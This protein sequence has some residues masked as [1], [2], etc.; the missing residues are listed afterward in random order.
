MLTASCFCNRGHQSLSLIANDSPGSIE[1]HPQDGGMRSCMQHRSNHQIRYL[2]RYTLWNSSMRIDIY[3]RK[4]K[5]RHRATTD[6]SRMLISL[7][8]YLTRELGKLQTC[9]W[10][11]S[12][13]RYLL[14]V[15]A[16]YNTWVMPAISMPI[17]HYYGFTSALRRAV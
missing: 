12:V 10:L 2:D 11:A 15:L 4:A 8:H 14:C 7:V 17:D 5:A 1:R 13:A 16:R 3:A 6:R 9:L